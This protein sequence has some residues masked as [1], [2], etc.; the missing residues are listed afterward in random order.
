MLRRDQADKGHE[1]RGGREAAR[2]P[3]FG[4][5]RQ[6]GQVIDAA[7]AAQPLDARPQRLQ[8]EQAAQVLLDGLQARDGF[9]D[10]PQIRA[11]R[12]L[13]RRQWPQLRAKP[14]VVPLGPGLL[15]RGEAAPVAEQEFREPMPSAQEI[16][17]D[18]LPAPEQVTRRPSWSVGM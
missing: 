9:V 10:G 4:G 13:E 16:G 14:R 17:A 8:V 11:M 7:E 5:D 18:I 6:R 3:E 1:A 15:R 12:L 2:I